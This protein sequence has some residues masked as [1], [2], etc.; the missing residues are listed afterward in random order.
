M[1]CVSEDVWLRFQD[2]DS[3]TSFSSPFLKG[4]RFKILLDGHLLLEKGVQWSEK[5]LGGFDFIGGLFIN[6]TSVVTVQFF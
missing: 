6:E 2:F 4:R 1:C 5:T 3:P